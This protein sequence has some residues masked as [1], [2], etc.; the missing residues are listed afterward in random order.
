M[1]VRC[2]QCQMIQDARDD[3]AGCKTICKS[4]RATF[5]LAAYQPPE[6]ACLPEP[7]HPAFTSM[8]LAIVVTIGIVS[9]VAFICGTFL[10]QP[11]RDNVA[12]EIAAIQSDADEKVNASRAMAAEGHGLLV[13][14]KMSCAKLEAEATR[15]ARRVIELEAMLARYQKPLTL[16][17]PLLEGHSFPKGF[18][19]RNIELVPETADSL[20]IVGEVKNTRSTTL[21]CNFTISIYH[22][23]KSVLD[24][25]DAYVNYMEPNTWRAFKAFVIGVSPYQV[26]SIVIHRR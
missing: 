25:A 10:T 3:S 22:H 5:V 16:G 4:C 14:Q 21:S 19:F 26:G 18:E 20:C 11:R 23:D 12:A 9:P 24:V 6:P 13:E 7:P 17:L 2:P 15:Y 1:K 8:L